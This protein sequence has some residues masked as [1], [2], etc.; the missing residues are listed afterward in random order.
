MKGGRNSKLQHCTRNTQKPIGVW[1]NDESINTRRRRDCA[2]TAKVEGEEK[3]V[4]SL[5]PL[6]ILFVLIGCC[7]SHQKSVVVLVVLFAFIYKCIH[8]DIDKQ[9]E[10]RERRRERDNFF[11]SARKLGSRAVDHLIFFFLGQQRERE[12]EDRE[13]GKKCIGQRARIRRKWNRSSSRSEDLLS[14]P[15]GSKRRRKRL[16]LSQTDKERQKY[17]LVQSTVT[18]GDP[19]I[20]TVTKRP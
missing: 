12:K 1:L 6:F 4:V 2:C 20:L 13:R 8:I 17:R 5:N 19:A 3:K 14:A 11:L 10:E 18:K 15:V 7:R 16:V 9:I